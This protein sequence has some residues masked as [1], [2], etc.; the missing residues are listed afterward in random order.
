M[1]LP[2]SALRSCAG[3]AEQTSRSCAARAAT[4]YYCSRPC[5]VAHWTSGGHNTVCVGLAQARCD[6]NLE[7]QSRALAH[8]AHMSGSAPDDVRCL[9][10]LDGGG[11][12]DRSRAGAGAAA[13]PGGRT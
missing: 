11:A 1:L 12:T 9:F 5:Q 13:R 6:A 7:V 2:P 8:V 10:C 4:L 3:C